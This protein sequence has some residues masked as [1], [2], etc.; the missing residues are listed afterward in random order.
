MDAPT[1][2]RWIRATR[3]QPCSICGKPDWC[4][5][6]DD[7][8]LCMR[9]ESPKPSRGEAGGW[10]HPLAERPPRTRRQLRLVSQAP[11]DFAEL[12]VRF[13][14]A[15]TPDRLLALASQLGVSEDAL[16]ATSIGWCAHRNAW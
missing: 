4:T 7:L 6:A 12:A 2:R 10:L 5:F 1:P 8:A 9:V 3:K 14:D 16:M 11:V 13:M 15:V